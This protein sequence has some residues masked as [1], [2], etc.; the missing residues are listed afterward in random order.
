MARPHMS[1]CV[2]Q[3]L[4]T[5]SGHSERCQNPFCNVPIDPLPNGDWRRTP[6]KFCSSRCKIDAFALRRVKRMIDRVGIAEFN[7]VVK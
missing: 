4:T 6:R 5:S 1:S 3:S 2:K 7:R